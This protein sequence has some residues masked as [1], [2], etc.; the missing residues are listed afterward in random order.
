MDDERIASMA[1]MR[2]LKRSYGQIA[3]ALG[4]TRNAALGKAG[5][6]RDAGD[7]RFGISTRGPVAAPAPRPQRIVYRAKEADASPSTVRERPRPPEVD[8]PRC[9]LTSLR[10]R[11]ATSRTSTSTSADTIAATGR[12]APAAPSAAAAT[13]PRTPS[14][15]I[16]Q[17]ERPSHGTPTGNPAASWT[18]PRTPGP[19][20]VVAAPVVPEAAVAPVA[21]VVQQPPRPPRPGLFQQRIEEDVARP[22]EARP[23]CSREVGPGESAS[24]SRSRRTSVE[25]GPGWMEAAGLESR[26][27]D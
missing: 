15:S 2:A 18:H 23:P 17:S 27:R 11:R 5:R 20:A 9:S 12:I 13:A 6:L 19:P 24:A 16:L 8:D 7:T 21:T 14:L 25:E 3:A 26:P 10:G 4:I 22:V 1:D